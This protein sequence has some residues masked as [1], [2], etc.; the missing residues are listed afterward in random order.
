MLLYILDEEFK[1]IA[2]ADQYST[3]LWTERYDECGDFELHT[4]PSVGLAFFQNGSYIWNKDS[5]SIMIIE[6]LEITTDIEDGAELIITGRSLESIL[7]RRIVW[8]KTTLTGNLQDGIK[9]LLNDA[10][11]SPT[12]SKR[13]ISNFVFKA[14]TDPIVT[15]LTV[16]IQ[17]RGETLYETISTL[18]KANSIGFRITLNNENK[19]VFELYSGVDRS[20]DQ[21]VK[22]YV[23]FTPKFNNL[24]SSDYLE[25]DSNYKTVTLVVG[26]YDQQEKTYTYERI[27]GPLGL[28][29]R[30]LY[31]EASGVQ[32]TDDSGST[33]PL[34]TFTSKLRQEGAKALK[35]YEEIKAFDGEIE[36][37]S[38]FV[39][40]VD[41]NIG[42]VVQVVNEYG[43]EARARITEIIRSEDEDGYT[44]Y[45][46]F[47]TIQEEN[48]E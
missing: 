4:V 19:F 31:T 38:F 7:D 30:E 18:C 6:G 39:Y 8:E 3:L 44:M 28:H 43:M 40:G 27:Y 37:T 11:I 12:D 1:S 13:K 16:D 36:S 34:D 9:K 20:Y 42:D 48:K 5:Q 14:S 15:A 25:S 46:T 41:Y 21:E 2:L 22:P 23:V 47:V 24:L 26:N 10:I 32:S 45:P 29:R 17:L 33:I 35:E